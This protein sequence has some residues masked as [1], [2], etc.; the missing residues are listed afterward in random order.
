MKKLLYGSAENSAQFGES[1]K[2]LETGEGVRV[3]VKKKKKKFK[4]Y[5]RL[6]F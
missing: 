5:D 1:I 4:N 6:K 2:T 3:K